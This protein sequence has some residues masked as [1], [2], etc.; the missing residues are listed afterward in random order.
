MELQITD[1][2]EIGLQRRDERSVDLAP[3]ITELVEGQ[4]RSTAQHVYE[5]N[6]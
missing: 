2:V 4:L 1:N 5:A 6:H 3:G